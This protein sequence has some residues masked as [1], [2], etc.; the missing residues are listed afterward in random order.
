LTFVPP[1]ASGDTFT[2][3]APFTASGTV[4]TALQ[5][6]PDFEFF[7]RASVAGSGV[8]TA[9]FVRAPEFPAPEFAPHWYITRAVY[10]FGNASPTPEPITF[11]LFGTGLALAAVKYRSRRSNER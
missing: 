10:E 6:G 5:G 2:L 1:S 9:T 4:G 3:T 11:A 8:V 7:Y